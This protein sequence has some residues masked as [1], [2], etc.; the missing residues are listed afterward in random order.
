MQ[1]KIGRVLWNPAGRVLSSAECEW[2]RSPASAGIILFARNYENPTQL[3]ELCAQVYECAPAAIITVDQEGGRVQRFLHQFTRLPPPARLGD[4]YV[5]E[6]A[7]ALVIAEQLGRITA[8]EL[9][10]CRIMMNNAPVLDIHRGISQVIGD[11][12][13]GSSA[14]Q[15]M[16]LAAAYV[17]GL[18]KGGVVA[19]GKHFPGHGGVVEDSHHRLPRDTRSMRELEED[20]MPFLRLKQRLPCMMTAHVI[21]QS[22][23]EKPATFSAVWLQKK[24][25]EQVNYAGVIISDDLCMGAVRTIYSTI[26]ASVDAALAA[27]CDLLLV[28]NDKGAIRQALHHIERNSIPPLEQPVQPPLPASDGFDEEQARATIENLAAP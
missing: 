18:H 23:D 4:L 11:R 17:E 7:R 13:W 5:K 26:E 9:H 20:M 6:P 1:K 12:S 2:L 14:E 28:C 22:V 27:G 21:Y 19:V 8:I 25:R 24:L 16:S 15:V 3:T 10:R